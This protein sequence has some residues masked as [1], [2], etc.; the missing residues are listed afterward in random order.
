MTTDDI[1][2][3]G[4]GTAPAPG[5]SAR[6]RRAIVEA[7]QSAFLRK[8][9][10]G[11]TMDEVAALAGVSKQTVYQHFAHKKSLFSDII[12]GEIAAAESRTS[13]L[14]D[15]LATT[16]DLE[17]DLRRFARKHVVDVIQPEIVRL[18][19]IVIAEAE[20]FPELA[21]TWWEHGPERAHAV[22]AEQ[23]RALHARGLLSVPD[24]TLAAQHLNW[25]LLSIPLHRATFDVGATFTTRELHRLADEGV[26]VFLAGYA[27]R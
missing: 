3:G 4:D 16:D 23:L 22:L 17:R 7:A 6:K 1:T 19:R 9:Y 26:R 27:V 25:L 5:R 14:V 13:G 8:G 20:Q 24:P 15:A 18:R 2:A 12:I 21:R 11:T 10:G